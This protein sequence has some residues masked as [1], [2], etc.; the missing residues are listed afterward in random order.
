M[1]FLST[2]K[3]LQKAFTSFVMS[4]QRP[5]VCVEQLGSHRM[6]FHEI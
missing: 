1:Q 2:I 5:S 6:D 4:V 3:K